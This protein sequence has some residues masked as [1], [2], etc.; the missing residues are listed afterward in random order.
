MRFPEKNT[1]KLNQVKSVVVGLVVLLLGLAMFL[2]WSGRKEVWFC[3]E[4]YS[5]QSANGFEQGWP[6]ENYGQWMS[7]E[8][9]SE[10]FSA[11][12]DKPALDYIGTTLYSD[13]VP[14]YFWIFRLVSYYGFHGSASLWI[15]LS[16]NLFFYLTL[17]AVG[18]KL[19]E[20]LTKR[21]LVAGVATFLTLIANRLMLQQALTLRM[22][23]MLVWTEVLLLLIGFWLINEKTERKGKLWAFIA[24]YLVSVFGFLTHYDFWI[25]YAAVAVLF[26]GRLLLRAIT[27]EKKHFWKSK[28]FLTAVAWVGNFAVALGTELWAFKYSRWNLFRDKGASAMGSLFDFSAE[29]WNQIKFGYEH[30]VITLFGEGFSYP[31]GYLI[32][33]GLIAGGIIVLYHKKEF[34]KLEWMI[35]TVLS[36]Q[37]YQNIVCFTMPSGSVERYLWGIY[38][39]M[40]MVTV[41]SVILLLDGIPMVKWGKMGIGVCLIAIVLLKQVQIVD[42]GKGIIYLYHWEKD[43]DRLE[44][45]NEV[46]WIVYGPQGGAYSYFDW[47]I[48]EEICF[49]SEAKTEE[50]LE[51]LEMLADESEV[52]LYIQDMYLE[53]AV[54]TLGE[55]M[56]REVQAEYLCNSSNLNVYV[57]K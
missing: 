10:F 45:K 25:Y 17:L 48:P 31:L 32:I 13:H 42:D 49:I 39:I 27:K 51:A 8:E 29:K 38:T 34:V 53:E 23:M 6:G 15:P 5:Y 24:L 50:E 2:Y 57:V 26:C 40:A 43:M 46:P 35:L 18:Y 54:Q 47:F 12:W 52:V 41:W 14:L 22:Y 11:D 4:V 9:V 33:F 37:L 28:D 21:P 20:G 36:M 44:S 19:F 1:G 16:I 30:L 56:G 55:Y 3:D 7:G